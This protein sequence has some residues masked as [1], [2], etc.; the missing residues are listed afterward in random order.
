MEREKQSERERMRERERERERMRQ[1]E[2]DRERETVRE[3][4]PEPERTTKRDFCPMFIFYQNH[5]VVISVLL[6]DF[7]FVHVTYCN[8]F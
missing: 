6:H 8:T 5:V 4:K 1:K 7:T 3:R 2:R